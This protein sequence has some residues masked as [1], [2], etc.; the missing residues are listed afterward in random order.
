M[1][2]SDPDQKWR[3]PSEPIWPSEGVQRHVE[4]NTCASRLRDGLLDHR[5]RGTR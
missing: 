3:T 1:F 4:C 5:R 2:P